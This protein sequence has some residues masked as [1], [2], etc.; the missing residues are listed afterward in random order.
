MNTSPTCRP[1]GNAYRRHPAG[2]SLCIL[3]HPAAAK[4]PAVQVRSYPGTLH[5]S[6]SMREAYPN[7]PVDA[8]T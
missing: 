7:T 5:P 1:S 2:S 3:A 6:P 8:R 4:M